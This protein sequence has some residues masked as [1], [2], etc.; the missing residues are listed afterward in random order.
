MTHPNYIPSRKAILA[1][2][3]DR[4]LAIIRETE[5]V[6]SMESRLELDSLVTG[7]PVYHPLGHT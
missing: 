6:R 2:T 1:V 7:D 5:Y 4:F 3:D